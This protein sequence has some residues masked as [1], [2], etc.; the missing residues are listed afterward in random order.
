MLT[1]VKTKELSKMAQARKIEQAITTMQEQY[2]ELQRVHFL[3]YDNAELEQLNELGFKL[4]SLVREVKKGKER[5]E[6]HGVTL[7]SY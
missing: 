2:D 4:M 3:A 6:R 5:L 1:Q 7:R